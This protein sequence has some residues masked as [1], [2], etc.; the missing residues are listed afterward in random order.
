MGGGKRVALSLC[1][2]G[3]IAL[4]VPAVRAGESSAVSPPIPSPC[5]AVFAAAPVSAPKVPT[6]V[7]QFH[8]PPAYGSFYIS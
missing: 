5:A 1:A 3:A 6:V 7:K 4:A 2:A 8:F